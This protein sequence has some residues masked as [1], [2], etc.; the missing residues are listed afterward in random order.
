MAAALRSSTLTDELISVIANLPN[1]VGHP[2]TR[3]RTCSHADGNL[4][5]ASVQRIEATS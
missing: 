2:P 1:K 4:E 5:L 3:F